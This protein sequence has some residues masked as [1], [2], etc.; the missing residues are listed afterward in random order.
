[1]RAYLE[2]D[3]IKERK[4]KKKYYGFNYRISDS[5]FSKIFFFRIG[6]AANLKCCYYYF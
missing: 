2:E 1:M 5:I 6:Y 3:N 4:S